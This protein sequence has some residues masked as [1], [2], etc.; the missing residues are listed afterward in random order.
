MTASYNAAVREPMES[1]DDALCA[2][3]A[4]WL[5]H[6]AERPS[7]VQKYVCWV[8]SLARVRRKQMVY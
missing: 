7:R 4:S 6:Q 1:S 3:N 5:S 8:E 2:K